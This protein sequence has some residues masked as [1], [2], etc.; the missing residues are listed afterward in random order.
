MEQK[1]FSFW[2]VFA[3]GIKMLTCKLS[4]ITGIPLD[5]GHFLNVFGSQLT[6]LSPLLRL[7]TV[8]G[9]VL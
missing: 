2:S 3:F 8:N 5:V 6:I 1:C 4:I 7:L 9:L